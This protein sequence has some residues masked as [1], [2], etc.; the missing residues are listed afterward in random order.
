[1]IPG[2]FAG[3]LFI[4]VL[5]FFAVYLLHRSVRITPAKPSADERALRPLS[6]DIR[7]WILKAVA[8]NRS[9]A[10]A[11]V[12]ACSKSRSM[13]SVPAY[14]KASDRVIRANNVSPR[15]QSWRFSGVNTSGSRPNPA[16]HPD[17]VPRLAVIGITS[18]T[19]PPPKN[20]SSAL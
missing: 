7:N 3:P 16:D 12:D 18:A 6:S 8:S 5:Q 17:S 10:V 14:P 4:A 2:K 1:M 15:L 9:R 20:S 19:K 11:G 13:R